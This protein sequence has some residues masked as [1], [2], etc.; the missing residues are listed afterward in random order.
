M[1]GFTAYALGMRDAESAGSAG[2]PEAKGF[3]TFCTFCTSPGHVQ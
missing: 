2:S 1:I 3:C